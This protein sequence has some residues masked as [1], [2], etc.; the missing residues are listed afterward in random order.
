MIHF[1]KHK[2][3]DEIVYAVQA[4][5]EDYACVLAAD[6][7][8]GRYTAPESFEVV[9]NISN[10]RLKLEGSPS[11]VHEIGDTESEMVEP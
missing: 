3:K 9:D 6:Y 1:I 4:A 5:N 11:N 2:E 8:P 7:A 10:I